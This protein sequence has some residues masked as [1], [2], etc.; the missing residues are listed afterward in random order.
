MD[1]KKERT[2]GVEGEGI[3]WAILKPRPQI[4]AKS[5]IRHPPKAAAQ[6]SSP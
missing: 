6:N 5:G 3:Q 1:W 4:R 2:E